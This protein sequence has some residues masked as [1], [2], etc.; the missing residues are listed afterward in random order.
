M[1]GA[2]DLSSGKGHRDENFPVASRLVRAELR[3]TILAFYRFARAA[4]DVADHPTAAP[5][6]KLAELD[7]TVRDGYMSY[8]FNRVL[9]S[10]FIFCTNELSAFYFDI[11]KD[12]L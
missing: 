10:V 9:N 6:Q 1:T 3:P 7:R 8:D 2:G 5:E 12:A 4:D 11:R